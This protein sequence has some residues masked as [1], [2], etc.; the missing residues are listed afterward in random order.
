M[1]HGVNGIAWL[2]QIALVLVLVG[3]PLLLLIFGVRQFR[4]S[5]SVGARIAMGIGVAVCATYLSTIAAFVW[6]IGPG[7]SGILVKGHSPEGMEY[8]VVQTFKDMVEPYQVSFYIRDADGLWR[9]NYLEHEDVAWG[10]AQVEFHGSVVKVSR[11][12]QP[13]RDI[14]MP[15]G[16]VDIATVQAGYR[17]YYCPAVYSAEDVLRF[18]NKKYRAER[19][20]HPYR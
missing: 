16:R 15:T 11:N 8:C 13:F 10:S 3:M 20:S 1:T 4:K 18:H 5:R 7:R 6:W 9:W 12:G 2:L 19:Q 17:D 14:P